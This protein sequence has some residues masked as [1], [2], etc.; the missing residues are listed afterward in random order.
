MA[1]LGYQRFAAHGGDI[2]SYVTNRL[3]L[4]YPAQLVGIHVTYPA[5]PHLDLTDPALPEEVR[6]FL[7]AR[8]TLDPGEVPA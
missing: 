4:E 3:A 2:G 6:S 7:A 5:E 1:V 8:P